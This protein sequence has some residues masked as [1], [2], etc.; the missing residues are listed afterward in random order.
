[1]GANEILSIA[2][3]QDAD[4]IVSTNIPGSQ[5]YPG[6]IPHYCTE[7]N[8]LI[9]SGVREFD[10]GIPPSMQR[11]LFPTLERRERGYASAEAIANANVM[12]FTSEAGTDLVCNKEGRPGHAQVS[13]INKNH[14]WDNFGF[15]TTECCPL[16]D[17]VTGTLVLEPAD[18]ITSIPG[19]QWVLEPV[20]LTF[21][22][23]YVTNIEGGYTATR[24][25]R[26]M[27][28]VSRG[29]QDKEAYGACH[30]GWGIINE[31]TP[32]SGSRRELGAY[33]HSAAGSVMVALGISYGFMSESIEWCGLM[34]QRHADSHTHMTLFNLDVYLD[35]E[36]VV[37]KGNIIKEGF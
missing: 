17:G 16:E 8:E 18:L 21:K 15:D 6:P 36:M 1:M 2:R 27:K 3:D 28:R 32:G 23:G 25:K 4:L 14:R 30:V 9:G 29:G 26:H 12:R 24:F 34:G 22:D 35:D 5:E 13:M 37:K 11:R 31:A 19:S 10:I 33:H 20:K 7:F